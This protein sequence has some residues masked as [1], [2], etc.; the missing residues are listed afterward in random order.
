[1]FAGGEAE[2]TNASARLQGSWLVWLV[3]REATSDVCSGVSAR[4]RPPGASP[5]LPVRRG[6]CSLGSMGPA[7]P[8]GSLGAIDLLAVGGKGAGPGSKQSYVFHSNKTITKNNA[9]MIVLTLCLERLAKHS[10]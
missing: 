9:Q 6:P 5:P 8:V 7:G 10:K 2:Q 3:W 1:M 4:R